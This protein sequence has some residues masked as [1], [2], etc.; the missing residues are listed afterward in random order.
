MSGVFF[1]P[2]FPI[3]IIYIFWQ[4]LTDFFAPKLGFPPS[5]FK[6]FD[7][8]KI[9]MFIL[10]TQ[11]GCSTHKRVCLNLLVTYLILML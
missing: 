1:N 2:A 11:R 10:M 4:T 8:M 5:S 6:Q 3:K 7:F 9:C